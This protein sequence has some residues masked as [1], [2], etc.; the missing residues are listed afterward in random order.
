MTYYH[1]QIKTFFENR[2]WDFVKIWGSTAWLINNIALFTQ[3]S[4]WTSEQAGNHLWLKR[5]G[6]PTGQAC[7]SSKNTL[8][9]LPKLD[10]FTLPCNIC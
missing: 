6:L 5:K 7:F 3:G 4:K 8:S 10:S 2:L 9:C 1:I